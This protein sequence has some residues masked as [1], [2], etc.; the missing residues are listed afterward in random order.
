MRVGILIA[1]ALAFLCGTQRAH[2]HDSNQS[3]D[4]YL[5]THFG[6]EEGLTGVVDDLVQTNDGFLWFVMNGK[7]LARFDGRRFTGFSQ[8]RDAT[9]LASAP[10][11]DLWVGTSTDLEQIPASALNQ[12]PPLPGA[13]YR[14]LPATSYR[15]TQN[16][17]IHVVCLRFGRSGVLWVGTT[18]GLYRFERGVFSS[19]IP[20]VTIIHMQEASNGHLLMVTSRGFIEWDGSHEVQQPNLAAELGVKPTDIYAVL[21]DRHGVVWFCTAK[22]VARRIGG[23]IEKLGNYAEGHGAFNAYEDPSGTV[24]FAAVPGLLRATSSGLELIAAHI[25]PRYL[26]SDRDGDLWI[27]TNGN[28]LFRFKD[29]AARMF[30]T[31]DGLPSNLVQTVLASRDGALWTGA[32]CGGL[33]RF[34]GHR[35]QTFNEKDGLLNSCVWTLAEDSNGDL[36]VGTW[37][38][39][40]FRFHGGKFTQLSKPQGLASDI[41]TSIVAARDGTLWF[42]MHGG[43]SHIRD[44]QI[45]NYTTADGLSS[46]AT[47]KVLEDGRGAIWVATARGLDRMVGDRF[48]NFSSLPQSAVFPIGQDRS[49][50]LYASDDKSGATFRIEGDRATQVS[51]GLDPLSMVQTGEDVWFIGSGIARVP[52]SE[53]RQSRRADDPFDFAKFGT[54]DGLA[55][56]EAAV[57]EPNSALTSDGRLWIATTQGLAMVDLT[58]VPRTD[59]VATIYMEQITVGRNQEV[60]SPQLSL[61]AGTHHTELLFDA[62]EISSPEKI[63]LQYRL[64]GVDSE[65]L[66]AGSPGRAIYSNIP[67]GTHAFHIRACNRDGIWDRTGM[68]YF[69]TQQPYFY[70]TIWFFLAAVTA[71]LLLLVSFYRF[72]LRQATDRLNARLEERLEERTR[73]ARELHD[74]FLQTV[75]GSK[76]VA[77]DLVDGS[78][79]PEHTR[80]TAEKLSEWLGK[81]T[82]EGRAAL[83]SLRTS[84][85]E[86]NDLARALQRAEEECRIR[87]S[88]EVSLSVIG[89]AKDMHPIV[90]DEVYRIGYEAIRNACV[91]SGGT[92]LEVSLTYANDLTL[93]VTDN[94]IGIDPDVVANGKEGHFGL[95]SMRE[96]A[97]R[98]GGKLTV[99]SPANS[100]AEITL[101]VPG[102][103]IFRKTNL[104]LKNRIRS[105]LDAH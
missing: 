65:W 105:F 36:W 92:R 97:E 73:M 79:D 91:H 103:T 27:G 8:P 22:G 100:G 86:A 3:T 28:G 64:D 9:T 55:T 82:E 104:G 38:G 31:G 16:K 29:R 23:S 45:R 21:E 87:T 1:A 13:S 80:R 81:A 32:N 12:F 40:A 71:G 67:V 90:R 52:A 42:A 46:N 24:W 7:L 5:R 51:P 6:P 50:T 48:V 78:G 63:R 77:D 4:S 37:G 58:R 70:Q 72:R 99:V 2:A 69:I 19:V 43:V 74:T 66:D 76:L 56:P 96:R 44:G 17:N 61:A 34:D 14:P 39:G 89:E 11:G 33:S 88:M 47:F 10:N 85:V 94:G 30:T 93:R 95:Q 98:I 41:V 102:R 84:T 60:P 20:G 75:Q 15:P 59:R 54:A 57:G 35:F 49:G 83:N 26:Y 68:V 25:E 101:V 18:D 62:V 53:L